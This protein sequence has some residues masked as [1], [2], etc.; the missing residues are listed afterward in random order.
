MIS[1]RVDRLLTCNA[2]FCRFDVMHPVNSQLPQSDLVKM[3]TSCMV[4]N[5]DSHMMHH[6]FME[7]V[8]ASEDTLER[9]VVDDDHYLSANKLS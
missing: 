8:A 5:S 4:A 7:Y 6:V 1:I 9:Q 3:K 2:C